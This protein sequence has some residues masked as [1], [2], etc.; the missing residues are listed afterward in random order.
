MRVAYLVSASMPGVLP[1]TSLLME[2]DRLVLRLPKDLQDLAGDRLANRVRQMARLVG[3]EP[4]VEI[5]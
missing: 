2:K 1:R 3:K 4:Q 5:V